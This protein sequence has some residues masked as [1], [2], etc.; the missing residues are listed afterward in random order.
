MDQIISEIQKLSTSP[1]FLLQ[2]N[3]HNEVFKLDLTTTNINHN[4]FTDAQI[5]STFLLNSPAN[6]KSIQHKQNN[7]NTEIFDRRI[8][9][10][11]ENIRSC[12][13]SHRS[14]HRGE[15]RRVICGKLFD[16]GGAGR[17]K[18]TTNGGVEVD[19]VRRVR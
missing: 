16:N 17:K 4:T 11:E 19:L 7:N 12:E 13:S 15:R 8:I 10:T 2:K 18:S 3:N 6:V 1:Y 14:P 5:N 9:N